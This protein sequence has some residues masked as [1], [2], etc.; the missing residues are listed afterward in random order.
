M[1]VESNPLTLTS[2]SADETHRLGVRL[3][4]LLEPGHVVGLVGELGAGKTTL[5]AGVAE[6]MGVPP[7]VYV[8]SPTFT[9]INEYPGRFPLVHVDFYRLSEPEDLVEIGLDE[10]YRAE[11]ACLVEWF[12]KFPE[13]APREHLEVTLEVSGSTSRRLRLRGAGARHLGLARAWGTVN[14]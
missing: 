5:A 8:S 12:D 1:T 3:G 13:A 9:L 2:D 10:Y 4:L 6:G 14:A 7:E 11:V